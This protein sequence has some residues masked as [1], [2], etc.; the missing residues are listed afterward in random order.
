MEQPEQEYAIEA[1][2]VALSKARLHL[3]HAVAQIVAVV[4]EEPLLLDE[5]DEHETVEHERCVPLTICRLLNPLDEFQERRV[6]VAKTIVE[7]L[8]DAVIDLLLDPA[9]DIDDS[10]TFLLLQLERN[11]RE[12]LDE[13]FVGLAVAPR[14]LAVP[15]GLAGL[16]PYPLPDLIFARRI[17]KDDEVFM[18]ELRDLPLNFPA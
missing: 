7:L 13:G 3:A 18:R 6:F 17:D 8:G 11:S 14:E 5:I 1:V 10:E 2:K 9:G 4:V 15:D 12:G 16:P